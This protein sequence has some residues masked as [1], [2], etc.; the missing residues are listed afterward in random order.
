MTDNPSRLQKGLPGFPDREP[1]AGRRPLRVTSSMIACPECGSGSVI[2]ARTH[3]K[4]VP[5]L[6]E[7]LCQ[8]CG[9]VWYTQEVE[10]S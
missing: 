5:G 1:T 2:I 9:H 8:V 7:R 4:R 10:C 6:R 3:F